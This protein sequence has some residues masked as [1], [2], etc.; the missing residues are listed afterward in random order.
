MNVTIEEIN[1]AYSNLEKAQ[2]K[3]NIKAKE[4]VRAKSS[5]AEAEASAIRDGVEGKNAEIRKANLALIV[6]IIK[7]I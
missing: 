3:F 5:L 4:H 6:E 7:E 1:N 2:V